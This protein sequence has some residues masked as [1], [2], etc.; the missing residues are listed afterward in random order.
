M[1]LTGVDGYVQ[2]ITVLV[3]FVVVLA[4]TAVVTKYIARYQ[5]AQGAGSN[6]EVQA[7]TFSW[8]GL[9]VLMPPLPYAR[10]R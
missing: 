7:N 3:I 8:Y 9:G 6:I 10:T 1:L 4:I 2:L 5:K